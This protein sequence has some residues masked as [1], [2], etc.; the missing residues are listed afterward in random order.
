MNKNNSALSK[1]VSKITPKIPSVQELREKIAVGYNRYQLVNLAPAPP[2]EARPPFF[3]FL[4]WLTYSVKLH[5]TEPDLSYHD[6]FDFQVLPQTGRTFKNLVEVYYKNDKFGILSYGGHGAI[7]AFAGQLQIENSFLYIDQQELRQ[8]IYWLEMHVGFTR[9]NVSRLDIAIDFPENSPL[10]PRASSLVTQ[11]Y[12][13]ELLLSGREKKLEIYSNVTKGGL[14][15]DGISLGNRSSAK[16]LRMYNKTK[17]LV[18]KPKR[19]IERYHSQFFSDQN[20]WRLEVQLN[21]AFWAGLKEDSLELSLWGERYLNIMHVALDGFFS[22]HLNQGKA[23]VN[24]NDSVDLINW[25]EIQ[26][27]KPNQW[28]TVEKQPR[29]V[30]D[31]PVKKV[32]RA[33]KSNFREYFKDQRNILP[34][35]ATAYYMHKYSLHNW[36][37][38]KVA[39]WMI[40]LNKQSKKLKSPFS[41]TLYYEHFSDLIHK[42]PRQEN[43]P[44]K[45]IADYSVNN[46]DNERPQLFEYV[47]AVMDEYEIQANYEENLS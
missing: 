27:L 4:D 29:N 23:E 38:M 44:N 18:N 43:K 32:Q 14:V 39:D 6:D 47:P 22:F 26:S 41:R 20:I 3:V 40:D 35:E 13:G 21:T 2:K 36:F 34:L 19:H 11:L 8:I 46:F 45:V 31:D 10:F 25:K 16:F 1:T 12:S 28:Q 37:E 17:E 42:Y 7:S 9:T 5:C 15:V 30:V 33:I 24:K